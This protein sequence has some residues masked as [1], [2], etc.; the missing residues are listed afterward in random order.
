MISKD[1]SV[2]IVKDYF[3]LTCLKPLKIHLI[4]KY[5]GIG[6]I[7]PIIIGILLTLGSVGGSTINAIV[8][9]PI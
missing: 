2:A 1:R 9:P 3:F 4:K 5:T 8:R 7:T 6:D